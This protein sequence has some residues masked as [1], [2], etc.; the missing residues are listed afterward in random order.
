MDFVAGRLHDIDGICRTLAI[1]AACSVLSV[2]YR[3]APGDP[4]PAALDDVT[5]AVCW[6]RDHAP[7]LGVD[8]ERVAIGGQSAGANLAAGCTLRLRDAGAQQPAFQ[9]LAYPVLDPSLDAPSYG[10]RSPATH[11]CGRP[12]HPRHHYRRRKT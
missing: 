3:L 2:E 7:L 9:V 5:A 10:E 8:A 6:V 4:F 1:D 12:H 11:D